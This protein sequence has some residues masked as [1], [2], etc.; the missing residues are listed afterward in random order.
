MSVTQEDL[1][2]I[3]NFFAKKIQAINAYEKR[4][5]GFPLG[6]PRKGEIRPPSIGAIEQAKYR[7]DNPV[8]AAERNRIAQAK[9]YSEN[10]EKKREA[11]KAC[12]ARKKG[13]NSLKAVKKVENQISKAR[14]TADKGPPRYER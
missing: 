14:K 11:S 7:A 13:W 9:W 8:L 3:K 2:F 1:I 4:R 10:R 12:R 6:R 5:S